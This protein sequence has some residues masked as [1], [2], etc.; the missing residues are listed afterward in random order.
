MGLWSSKS[1]Y[2]LFGE[3][4]SDLQSNSGNVHEILYYLGTSERNWGKACSNKKAPRGPAWLVSW[5]KY[6]TGQKAVGLQVQI[7]YVPCFF[8]VGKKASFRLLELP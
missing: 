8:F 4:F 1:S 2:L 3:G 6:E 7:L 5:G